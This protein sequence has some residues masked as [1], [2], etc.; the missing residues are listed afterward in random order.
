MPQ[1]CSASPSRIHLGAK[2]E[3][4]PVNRSGGE[5]S[6][7][8]RG[9]SGRLVIHRVTK[10]VSSSGPFLTLTKTNYHDW[11]AL[12]WVML[13]AQ[14]LR[15]TVSISMTDYTDDC[16]A[17]EVLTKAILPELMETITNK[18]TAKAAWDSLYL[19]NISAKH[20]HMVRAS[21]L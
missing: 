19:Q 5:E 6:G 20:V 15:L 8:S 18:T 7:S 10:E 13:Q 16:M 4:M 9:E 14:G 11:V 12:M 1:T 3:R 17:L 21:M 2:R